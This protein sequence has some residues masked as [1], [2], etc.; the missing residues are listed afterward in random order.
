MKY[1]LW[2]IQGLLAALFLFAGAMKFVMPVAEMTKEIQLP[3]LLLHFIGV[4]EILGGLGLVLPALLKIRP[5]L[6]S[7]AAF[8]L[9]II[10]I[11]AIVITATSSAPAQAAVPLVVALALAFVIYGRRRLRSTPAVAEIVALKS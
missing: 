11:G 10:M 1:A 4:C 2:I 9:L 7:L 6:T 5:G 3:G 8:G